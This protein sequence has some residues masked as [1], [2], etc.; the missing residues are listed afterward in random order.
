MVNLTSDSATT[1]DNDAA[2]QGAT[3][4][5]VGTGRNHSESKRKLGH[6]AAEYMIAWQCIM[7]TLC[8]SRA[9]ND[10]RGRGKT[11]KRRW[12]HPSL[13]HRGIISATLRRR[14]FGHFLLLPEGG[15]EN[16]PTPMS[17]HR[18]FA[19]IWACSSTCVP[20]SALETRESGD[21]APKSSSVHN[22]PRINYTRTLVRLLPH[23]RTL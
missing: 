5:A 20:R 12:T 3:L 7:S 1:R 17:S 4:R 22:I 15:D 19:E 18:L 21:R 10:S 16:H 2:V 9:T 23:L 8:V 13:H 11:N 6:A 14:P